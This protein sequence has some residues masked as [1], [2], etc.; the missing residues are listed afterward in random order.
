MAR[1][2]QQNGLV[3]RKKIIIKEMARS[4]MDEVDVPH[5][6]WGEETQETLCPSNR[7]QLKTNIDNTSYDIWKG[8]YAS[9]KHYNVFGRK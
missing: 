4:M 2:P 8:K 6:F 9:V 7:T 1:T 5:I 3:E